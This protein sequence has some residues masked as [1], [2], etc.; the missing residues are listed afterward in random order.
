MVSTWAASWTSG[1]QA[2]GLGRSARLRA[3]L[4]V[5]LLI[6]AWLAAPLGAAAETRSALIIGNARYD[7]VPGLD[8]PVSDAK[9]M[10]EKLRGLGFQV[11]EH[12]DADRNELIDAVR[13]FGEVARGSDVG[14]FYYAGHA[15]QYSGVNYVVPTDAFLR[16]EQDIEFE[17]VD[18][19]QILRQLQSQTTT[20]LIFLDSCRD[21]PFSDLTSVV[22]A[23]PNPGLAPVAASRGTFIAYATEPNNVAFDSLGED[24][25]PFTKALLRHIDTAGLEIRQMMTR[26]RAEVVEA[27]QNRQVPWDHSS[28]LSEFY[29]NGASPSGQADLDLDA[30]NR[31]LAMTDAGQKLA[32]LEAFKSERPDSQLDPIVDSTIQAL[33]RPSG[34]VSTP[35]F[36][37]P[38]L[39]AKIPELLVEAGAAVHPLGLPPPRDPDGD[40]LS[41]AVVELPASGTIRSAGRQVKVGDVL[42]VEQLTGSVYHPPMDAVG[43]VGQFAFQVAD[44]RGGSV[45]GMVPIRILEANHPPEMTTPETITATVGGAPVSIALDAPTDPDPEDQVI[46]R[47]TA[48]PDQGQLSLDGVPLSAGQAVT[49]EQLQRMMYEPPQ[50]FSP[51]E[52]TIGLLAEDGRGGETTRQMQVRLNRPPEFGRDATVTVL[53]DDDALPLEVTPPSDPDGDPLTV[54]VD[55]VPT[56]GGRLLVEDRPVQVGMELVAAELEQLTFEPDGSFAGYA[57]RLVL[58]ARDGQGGS[59]RKSLTLRI[60]RPNRLPV[61]PDE[62]RVVSVLAGDTVALGIGQPFDPDGHDLVIVVMTVPANG[63]V[64]LDDDQIVPSSVL[65]AT[66]LARLQFTADSA[67]A[68]TTGTLRYAVGDGHGGAAMGIAEITVERANTPPVAVNHAITTSSDQPPPPLGVTMPSDPDGDPLGIEIMV[69]P[70]AGQALLEERAL[71]PGDRITLEELSR[72]VFKVTELFVGGAG[73]FEYAVEDGRGG[74]TVGRTEVTVELPN[75]PPVAYA[76]QP[77]SV[78]QGKSAPLALRRPFDPDRDPLAITVTAVPEAGAVTLRGANLAMGATLALADLDGL[79]FSAEDAEPGEAGRFA[80]VVRDERGGEAAGGIELRVLRPNLPPAVV[81]EAELTLKADGP[82]A[83]LLE[84]RMPSDPDGDPL[85]ATILDLPGSGTVRR[86]ERVL[87]AGDQLPLAELAEAA[88]QPEVTF[89]GA[90][91]LFRYRVEDGHGGQAVAEIRLQVE[92][93]NR[94]PVAGPVAPLE[95]VAGAPVSAV[96]LDPPFDPDGDVLIAAVT[97]VPEVAGLQLSVGERAIERGAIITATELRLLRLAAPRAAAG[98]GG[99]LRLEVRDGRGGTAVT[100]IDLEIKAPSNRPPVVIVPGPVDLVQG[101]GAQPL[102]LDQP[103]DLDGDALEIRLLAL[104]AGSRGM[105]RG[106]AL[107]A[108]ATLSPADLPELNLDPGSAGTGYAGTLE[109]EAIDSQGAKTRGVV[110][111]T[112]VAPPNRPP[113]IPAQPPMDAVVGVGTVPLPFELPSDPDGDQ[114]FIR[115]SQVPQNG[116]LTFKNRAAAAEMVLTLEE[117]GEARFTPTSERMLTRGTSS[118]LRYVADDGRGGLSEGEVI[119]RAVLHDCDRLASAEDNIESV[120]SGVPLADVQAAEAI[121]GCDAAL[122]E[123]GNIV[124]FRF[125]LGRALQAGGEPGRALDTYFVAALAGDSAAQHNLGLLLL[126]PPADLAARK[127]VELGLSWLRKAAEAGLVPAQRNLAAAL[128]RLAEDGPP[129]IDGAEAAE[130]LLTASR[131]SDDPEILTDLAMAYVEGRPGLAKDPGQA[132]RLL[133]RAAGQDYAPAQTNLGYV[134]AAGLTGAPDYAEAARWLAAAAGHEDARAQLNLGALYLRGQGVARDPVRAVRSYAAAACATEAEVR[135][136]A[137]GHLG[138]LAQPDATAA[139]QA[140]LAE[141]GYRPG[142]VD[143]RLGPA[144]RQALASFQAEAGLAQSGQVS[145]DTLLALADCAD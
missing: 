109:V 122:A 103:V 27:T 120:A 108:G 98:T 74:R 94:P 65:G 79:A 125:Q 60:D 114:L 72:V 107:A 3:T 100:G 42:S 43:T 19:N 1:R 136:L 96:P 49:A 144:T 132:V 10:A 90:A 131:Q 127:D 68:G 102:G 58:E 92:P 77:L 67:A 5:L 105:L 66:D 89:V 80:Y 31:I 34:P 52:S 73:S 36:N 61:L 46:V 123:Y 101:G 53:A 9:A 17:L 39:L 87:A 22:R 69:L 138:R 134:Y 18:V 110:P 119:I 113:V 137:L 145:A 142:P 57:G 24:H 51:D 93:A 85:R 15:I 33:S 133:E 126:D 21:N 63:M 75:R 71:R 28:L 8:T 64:T 112:V 40:Q 83:V 29:F 11:F 91:G 41:V 2:S 35:G 116:V 50:A 55:A 13:E 30:L 118:T 88:Y 121:A 81:A 12:L 139:A 32:A 86:G 140:L 6:A 78:E 104:P 37:R 54:V 111:V 141:R 106:E 124:R 117:F 25:S 44:A 128:W 129:G 20:R 23:T 16:A 48:V 143:G 45:V 56:G 115:I 7:N 4:Y 95:I 135:T 38:P 70:T 26:V 97:E 47:F 59:A 62:Q 76:Q 82:A 99:P 84:G 14:L 130:W